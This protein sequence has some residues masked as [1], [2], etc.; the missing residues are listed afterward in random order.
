MGYYHIWLSDNTSNLCTIIIPWGKY[1]HKH[2]TI[3]VSNYP[4]IF[5]KKMNGLFHGFES[6]PTF[7]DDLLISTNFYWTDHVQKLELTLNKMKVKWLKFNIEHSFFEQTEIKYLWLWVTRNGV[8]P[9]DK[10]IEAIKLWSHLLTK[11]KFGSL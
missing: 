10:K 5:Q 3:G 4:Y 2:L 7:I 8:K 11:N 1:C 6:I 9:V